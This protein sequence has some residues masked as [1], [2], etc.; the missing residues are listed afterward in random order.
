[1]TGERGAVGMGSIEGFH[2]NYHVNIGSLVESP[3]ATT[4]LGQMSNAPVAAFDPV[5]WFHHCQIDRI[6]ELWRAFYPKAWFPTPKNSRVK[7]ES[8]KNLLPFYNIAKGSF[9]TSND[10][11]D[12]AALGYTYGDLMGPIDEL[13]ERLNLKYSWMR[14]EPNGV[15][16]TNPEPFMAHLYKEVHTSYFMTGLK[17]PK[18]ITKPVPRPT[19]NP[20]RA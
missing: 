14:V 12:T 5:F 18:T 11:K 16:I 7:P 15:N 4:Y 9:W 3:S 19:L 17:N 6:W 10:T 20:R 1:M 8:E 2:G 13:K